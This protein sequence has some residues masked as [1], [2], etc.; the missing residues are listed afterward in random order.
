MAVELKASIATLYRNLQRAAQQGVVPRSAFEAETATLGLDDTARARLASALLELGLRLEAP[1]TTATPLD[2]S[3]EVK[4]VA[5]PR[6]EKPQPEGWV[7]PRVGTALRLLDRYVAERAVPERAVAGVARLAGLTASETAD[8]RARAA[9][10]F[11]L[12]SAE[13]EA[14]PAA[15]SDMTELAPEASAPPAPAVGVGVGVGVGVEES[16]PLTA[17]LTAAVA[18]AR[19]VIEED[20]YTKRPGKR[21]LTALEEVG[22][23]VLLRGGPRRISVEPTD[24]ELGSL[25]AT[26]IRRRARDCL[27]VHNQGLVWVQ[28]R[29]HLGQGL[30]EDDLFQH[31]M[32]GVLRAARKFDPAHGN[33][34]STYATWWVRQ[35]ITR[36][37]ADE[38]SAIRI[39]VHMHELVRKVGRVERELLSAGKSRSAAAV[40]VACDLPV[41]KVEEIRRISKVTDSTD[42]II[43]DGTHLGELLEVRTALPSVEVAVLAVL[44]DEGVH[45]LVALL[46]ERYARIV[47]LRV[48]LDGTPPATLDAIGSE[49]GVTRERVRQLE[50]QAF[51]VLRIALRHPAGN[52]YGALSEML[53]GAGED[54]TTNNPVGAISRDL[55]KPDWRAGIEALTAFRAREGRALP[56]RNHVEDGFPLGKWVAQ[57]RA[58]GGVGGRGLPVQRRLLLEILGMVWAAPRSAEA[59]ERIRRAHA[60]SRALRTAGRHRRPARTATPPAPHP[61]P[62]PASAAPAPAVPETASIEAEQVAEPESR[63]APADALKESAPVRALSPATADAGMSPDADTDPDVG[64]GTDLHAGPDPNT[65]DTAPAANTTDTNTDPDPDANA[66]ANDAGPGADPTDALTTADTLPAPAATDPIDAPVPTGSVGTPEA[67]AEA[68]AVLADVPGT[69]VGVVDD[70]ALR[71]TSAAAEEATRRLRELEAEVADRVAR[72]RAAERNHA[73][74]EARA[75][76]D[77]A[78]RRIRALEAGL[79]DRIAHARAEERNSARAEARAEAEQQIAAVRDEAERLVREAGYAAEERVRQVRASMEHAAAEREEQVLRRVEEE[80]ARRTL[81][82]EEAARQEVLALEARLRQA[83]AAFAER[84]HAAQA[85]EQDTAERVRAAERWAEQRV[86]EAEQAVRSHAAEVERAARARTAEVEQ[87]ARSRIA[88]LEARLASMHETPAPPYPYPYPA[89]SPTPPPAPTPAPTPTPAP[90][91]APAPADSQQHDTRRWWRRG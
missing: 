35:S 4:K 39:P 59:Q 30:D 28:A 29:A 16:A 56:E 66:N 60:E 34:F 65:T 54:G 84:A 15:T 91:P 83:E 20:R 12:L 3:G 72:A 26:D 90:A 79:A 40:A 61:V 49:L 36:A 2:D 68:P 17:G 24:E 37:L 75:E 53:T 88:E 77:E 47:T 41:G 76:V 74:A 43:G 38:G 73:R 69:A 8:M 45:D 64:A 87:A 31:G 14:A 9:A 82:I 63:P 25:P 23:S 55:G 89:P 42:R 33:K 22:L 62:A 6:T 67:V 58:E 13:P 19:A 86:A 21:I 85:L 18:A 71:R 11:T 78:T 52:P 81:G 80:V 1:T 50:S 44:A 10:R 32:I 48:G 70:A 27:A 57:Q 7:Q 46:P 51:S 5:G